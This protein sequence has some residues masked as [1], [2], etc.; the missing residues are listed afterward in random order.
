MSINSGG[1]LTNGVA[2]ASLNNGLTNAG[3]V[4][5]SQNTYFNG[6]VTNTGAMFFQGAISNGLVNPGSFNLNNNATLTAAPVNKGAINVAA[7]T[8]TVNPDWASAGTVQLGGGVLSGGNLTNNS[9]ANVA[10]FGTVSNQLVNAGIVTATNGNLNL[11]G[12]ATG[13]GGIGPW[14]GR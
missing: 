12:A 6:P 10:G 4:F 3:T 8:L 7:S 5:V 2:G 13:A 1:V 9:G 11:V 14:R